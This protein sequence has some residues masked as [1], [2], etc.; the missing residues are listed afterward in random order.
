MVGDK[1]FRVAKKMFKPGGAIKKDGMHRPEGAGNFDNMDDTN[2]VKSINS[3]QGTIDH[4]PANDKDI[5]N[6]KYVDDNTDAVR[7]RVRNTSGST[8]TRGQT[9]FVDGYNA[10]QDLPTVDL[11]DASSSSTMPALGVAEDDISNNANGDCLIMG[12]LNDIDTSSFSAGADIFVSITA[13]GVSAKPTGLDLVQRI[14][15]ILRSHAVNGVVGVNVDSSE[16]VSNAHIDWTVSLINFS[17][18]GTAGV[19]ILSPDG[20]MHIHEGNAGSVTANTAGDTLTLENNAAVGLSLLA[21]DASNSNIFFGSPSSNSAALVRWNHNTLKNQVG[22]NI[23]S[24]TYE[25]L[26]GEATLALAIDSSQNFNFQDGNLTTTGAILG[27]GAGHDQFSDFVADE[28]IDWTSTSSN[29]NTSGTLTTTG[30]FTSLGIDDNASAVALTIDASKN[31]VTGDDPAQTF[32]FVAGGPTD[33][34]VS[35]QFRTNF[36][37]SSSLDAGWALFRYQSAITSASFF[38]GHARGTIATP[39][40]LLQNDGTFLTTGMAFDGERFGQVAAIEFFVDGADTELDQYPGRIVLSTTPAAGVT[41]L[42]RMEIDRDGNVGI[43]IT[44]PR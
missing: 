28:H 34:T 27:G 19:G 9:M 32:L 37:T 31:V 43:G 39:T 6:K 25:I 38:G 20:F 15:T 41:P 5:V 35:P 3:L 10:G 24:G 16:V 29:F 2:F 18:I 14:G 26:T 42:D 7:V 8:I 1:V 44:P 22:T 33:L 13:G 17:T 4:T 23:A 21:P 11:A 36:E 12:K 30:A 40:K